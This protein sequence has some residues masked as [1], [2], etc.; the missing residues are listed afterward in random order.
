[1]WD[2]V[3][4]QHRNQRGRGGS[5]WHGEHAQ[6]ERAWNNRAEEPPGSRHGDQTDGTSASFQHLQ[7]N[8]KHLC[9]RPLSGVLIALGLAL[10]LTFG[11]SIPDIPDLLSADGCMDS[12]S[13]LGGCDA[14][15]EKVALFSNG[16]G[17]RGGCEG[18]LLLAR[19]S[20]QQPSASRQ[21]RLETRTHEA[22]QLGHATQY[23]SCVAVPG[24]ALTSLLSLCG[25]EAERTDLTAGRGLTAGVGWC[26]VNCKV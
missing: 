13:S 1:M 3:I 26:G 9:S 4:K 21:A 20:A 7:A 14:A 5:V 6:D 23:S 8:R 24:L 22:K 16:L 18:D 10:D 12:L 2:E 25:P 11:V 19:S 17:D 15:G